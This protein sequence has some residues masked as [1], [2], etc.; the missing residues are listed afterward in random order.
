MI[1]GRKKV[2]AVEWCERSVMNGIARLRL[3]IGNNYLGTLEEP[4][5]YGVVFGQLRRAINNRAELKLGYIASKKEDIFQV[6]LSEES[7]KYLL[8]FGEAFDDFCIFGFVHESKMYFVW[9]LETEP[10]FSYP[11]Y[12]REVIMCS[13]PILEIESVILKCE[14]NLCNSAK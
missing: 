5:M 2:F 7:G 8:S 14:S 4:Q 9:Q 12:K 13:V 10:F 3:W 6:L 11:N 1:K